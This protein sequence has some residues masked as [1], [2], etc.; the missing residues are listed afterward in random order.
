MNTDKFLACFSLPTSSLT[1]PLVMSTNLYLFNK[2]GSGS[3]NSNAPQGLS[4]AT[5]EIQD[6]AY[7]VPVPSVA[8]RDDYPWSKFFH[9]RSRVKKIPNPGSGSASKKEFKDFIPKTVSKLSKKLSGLFIPDSD[10]FHPV[11]DPES[12]SRAQKAPYP[13][14][15]SATL[16]VPGYGTRNT[17]PVP[18]HLHADTYL[19]SF[20]RTCSSVISTRGIWSRS[21]CLTNPAS[22]GSRNITELPEAPDQ[23]TYSLLNS[24]MLQ[25]HTQYLRRN[26]IA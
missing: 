9:P 15:G 26:I 2:D 3:S 24:S 23:N 4:W 19:R 11:P 16:P 22:L 1:P 21:S 6:S 10:F 8:I 14:S 18:Y 13:G 5:G 7:Y 17:Y 25:K 20:W 12:E